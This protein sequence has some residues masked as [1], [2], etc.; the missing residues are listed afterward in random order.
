MTLPKQDY[1]I[2]E[3]TLKEKK[4]PKKQAM[5][6]KYFNGYTVVKVPKKFGKGYT[7][8]RIYTDFWL[9]QDMPDEARKRQKQVFLGA[10]LISVALY[11]FGSLQKVPGNTWPVTAIFTGIALLCLTFITIYVIYYV[12]RKSLMTRYDAEHTHSRVRV[13]SRASA[14]SLILLAAAAGVY[15]AF[16]AEGYWL[17]E[18]INVVA[19]ALAGVLQLLIYRLENNTKYREKVNDTKIPFDPDADDL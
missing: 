9:T 7:V 17:R 13:W 6:Q 15:T 5:F 18:T 19:Y 2:Y 11:L 10:D 14:V 4:K 12:T 16:F 1:E 3:E 8:T